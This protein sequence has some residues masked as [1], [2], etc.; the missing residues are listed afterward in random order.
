MSILG[1]LTYSWERRKESDDLNY[2]GLIS[3]Y[4]DFRLRG[5]GGA[6]GKDTLCYRA[7]FELVISV[8][9]IDTFGCFI[10]IRVPVW[11][12]F[13]A[14]WSLFLALG[15]LLPKPLSLLPTLSSSFL[16]SSDTRLSLPLLWEFPLTIDSVPECIDS[17]G[18]LRQ[19][20]SMLTGRNSFFIVVLFL[21]LPLFPP[22]MLL[23]FYAEGFVLSNGDGSSEFWVVL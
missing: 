17:F 19:D 7:S 21:E 22:L 12:L 8:D 11:L 15:S 16:D 14:L 13:P 6:S 1:V 9:R 23:K 2:V 4:E 3:S 18:D 20:V 5:W 10:D